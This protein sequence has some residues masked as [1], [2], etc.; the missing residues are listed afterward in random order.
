MQ[1]SL[2]Q[3]DVA[4]IV[5]HKADK[6]DSFVHLLYAEPLT[7]EH[8][9]VGLQRSVLL[10]RVANRRELARRQVFHRDARDRRHGAVAVGVAAVEPGDLGWEAAAEFE[11]GPGEARRVERCVPESEMWDH[12]GGPVP[13]FVPVTLDALFD[14]EMELAERSLGA[15]TIEV[16][17]VEYV[18][19][20]L[21]FLESLADLEDAVVKVNDNVPIY[22]RN[23]AHVTLGPALRRGSWTR[24]ERK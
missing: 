18:I 7:G 15:R 11:V 9:A 21:G 1:C 13:G 22:V 4:Q 12:V 10:V 8:A 17:K 2:L 23:V 16:N 5:V 19:R 6:P 3:V 20:G 14:H 24:G